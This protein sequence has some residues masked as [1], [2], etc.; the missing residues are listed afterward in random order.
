MAINVKISS[1]S[2]PSLE[3]V[4]ISISEPE[5]LS[6]KIPGPKTT[7]IEYTLNMRR[8]LNGDIMIFDHKEIDIMVLVE[9]KK[10]VAF[11]KD[12]VGDSVYGAEKRLFD[13]LRKR[14]VVQ[15]DSIEGGNVFGSLQAVLLESKEVDSTK[16]ALYEIS[17]WLDTEKPY[18]ED[19]YKDTIEDLMLYPDTEESTELGEVP[20][21]EEKGSIKQHGLFAPYLYGRYTY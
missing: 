19:D 7:M 11:A 2:Q 8:T 3:P 5:K 15:Y 21:E 9:K 14:G 16:M 4:R 17:K 20:H 6:V 1:N 12:V 13:F 18:L 10:I